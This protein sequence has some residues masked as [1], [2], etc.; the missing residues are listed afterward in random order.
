MGGILRAAYL[1]TNQKPLYA[2]VDVHNLLA[3][4]LQ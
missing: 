1:L 2:V 3:A 4:V